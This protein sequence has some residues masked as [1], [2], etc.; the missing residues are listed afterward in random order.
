L[1]S[2]AGTV[3]G[4]N[5]F[6][7]LLAG[8]AIFPVVFAF[9]LE[10]EQGPGLLFMVLPSVFSQLPLGG[11]FL[12]MFLLLF[13]FAT[14]TS[15]FSLYEIIVA[16]L[17]ANGKRTRKSA[18]WLTGLVIFIAAIPAALSSSSL[19]E[20]TMFGKS[21]F[22]ATD[23]LVSNLMLPFGNLL[24]AIF[25]IHKMDQVIV[26]EEFYLSSNVSPALFST[27]SFLMKWIV[28]IT[29]VVVFL[30]TLGII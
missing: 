16:A 29:I 18:S 21:I 27:W 3:V 20:F 12:C 26:K 30:N 9:G 25:I 28:P 19:S 15:S 10:P 7:S 4:L 24:I 11:L 14:L 2:S 23:Y 17:T 13:L 8:L 22:D 5:I 6:V 1:T